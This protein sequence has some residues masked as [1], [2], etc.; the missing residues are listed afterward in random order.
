MSVIHRAVAGI[1]HLK[2]PAAGVRA[3]DPYVTVG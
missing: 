2:C 1:P 3:Q